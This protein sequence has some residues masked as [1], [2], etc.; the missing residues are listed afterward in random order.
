MTSFF[1]NP[2]LSSDTWKVTRLNLLRLE[3]AKGNLVV[4]KVWHHVQ[5][6]RLSFSFSVQ[7]QLKMASY[8]SE[9]PIRAPPSPSAVSLRFPQKQ[10]QY[11][12]D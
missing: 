5:I 10:S 3:G 1:E 8:C 12:S 2:R 9:R 11:L 6:E 4:E 7:F